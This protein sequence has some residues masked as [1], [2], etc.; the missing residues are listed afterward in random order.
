MLSKNDNIT[1]VS[2]DNDPKYKKKKGRGDERP[3]NGKDQVL[4]D[5]QRITGIA[6]KTAI[7]C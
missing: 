4:F 7:K 1:S 2:S 3:S 6:T 5:L